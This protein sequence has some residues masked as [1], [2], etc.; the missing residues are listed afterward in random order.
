MSRGKRALSTSKTEAPA[1]A[2]RYAAVDPAGPAP[3]TIASKRFTPTILVLRNDPVTTAAVERKAAA[4]VVP[5]RQT[6]AAYPALHHFRVARRPRCAFV[7][8]T[9]AP[10]AVSMEA[11]VE[12]FRDANLHA[13]RQIAA[14]HLH[15]EAVTRA[16]AREP[17]PDFRRRGPEAVDPVA[18][19]SEAQPVVE[20]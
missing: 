14:V 7:N 5:A 19:R 3:T 15:E 13:R 2:R 17:R 9:N 11:S 12:S 20:P 10:V 8:D 1:V 4:V 16:E 18:V 6:R